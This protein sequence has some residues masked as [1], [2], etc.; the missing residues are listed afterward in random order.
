MT[1][2]AAEAGWTE[3]YEEKNHD[4][5]GGRLCTIQLLTG[6]TL[7]LLPLLEGLVDKM[8][9]SLSTARDAKIQAV[10]VQVGERRLVGVRF[11]QALIQPLRQ[12]LLQWQLARG[13]AG[14]QKLTIEE[15][16][17]VDAKALAKAMRPQTTIKSFFG[18]GG[19]GASSSSSAASAPAA[20]VVDAADAARR[21][22]PVGRVG[23]GAARP[24]RRRRGG[25]A[26]A[27]AALRRRGRR[28]WRAAVGGGGRRRPRAARRRRRRRRR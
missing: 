10:R 15:V 18:G 1:P 7:P 26:P 23:G 16:T 4:K 28:V 11:P 19:G 3:R 14:G 24:D 2:E 21:A 25:G 13:A 27:A 20:D 8:M 22:G 9:G 6:S 12:E 5:A 17:A